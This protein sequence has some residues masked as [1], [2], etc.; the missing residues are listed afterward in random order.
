MNVG[1][2]VDP[3]DLAYGILSIIVS[4]DIRLFLIVPLLLFI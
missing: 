1:P 3:F 4:T 2:L